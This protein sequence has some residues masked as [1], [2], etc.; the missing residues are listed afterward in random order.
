MIYETYQTVKSKKFNAI[1]KTFRLSFII[2]CAFVFSAT[3]QMQTWSCSNQNYPI[4]LPSQSW[5]WANSS[6]NH[7]SHNRQ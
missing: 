7:A 5:S 6:T 1:R 4:P 3:P 2:H